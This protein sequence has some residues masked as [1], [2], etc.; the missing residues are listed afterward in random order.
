VEEAEGG[1]GVRG[2]E[3]REE[4]VNMRGREHERTGGEKRRR[5]SW[6]FSSVYIY[7]V[8]DVVI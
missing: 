5:E 4:H 6:S 7:R 8:L 1:V 2:R 3:G